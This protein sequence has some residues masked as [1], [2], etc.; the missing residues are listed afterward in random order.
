MVLGLESLFFDSLLKVIVH[1]WSDTLIHPCVPPALVNH[2]LVK[3]RILF[4]AV[5]GALPLHL[6]AG[7]DQS[8]VVK[9]TSNVLAGIHG[10]VVYR[11]VRARRKVVPL[12]T[13]LEAF[14]VL[15]L[16]VLLV[17]YLSS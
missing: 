12:C 1:R 8:A 14:N 13:V 10:Q 7:L 15:G 9:S 17:G 16:G 6:H 2:A 3:R 4:L 5:R 11:K